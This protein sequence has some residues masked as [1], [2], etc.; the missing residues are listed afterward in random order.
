MLHKIL[1]IGATGML[2]KP[3][4][5]QCIK[6]GFEVTVFSTNKERASKMFPTATILEGNLKNL[7]SVRNA[8]KGQ[9]IVYMNLGIPTNAKQN[10]WNPEKDGVKTVVEE[11]KKAGIKRIGYL[12]PKIAGYGDWWV[13]QDKRKAVETIKSSGIPYFIFTASSFMD[14]FNSTQKDG[15]KINVIG[16]SNVKMF[17]IAASDYA[18]QVSRAFSLEKEPSNTFNIQGSESYR[19]NEAAEV[20]V[21]NH[22]KEKLKVAKAPMGLLKFIGLFNPTLSYVTKLMEALNNHPEKFDAQETWD[23]LGKP[24]IRLEQFAK[25]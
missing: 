8:L 10:E 17:Y 21:K 13:M 19:I 12:S 16:K 14:N 3:I 2:G 18:K 11:A 20:F 15:N 1:I 22:S 6:D 25:I 5:E 24:T 9:D 4:T 23:K 7:D